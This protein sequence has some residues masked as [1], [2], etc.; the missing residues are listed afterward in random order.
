MV[1]G[2]CVLLNIR[3]LTKLHFLNVGKSSFSSAKVIT[4]RIRPHK[5]SIV[6]VPRLISAIYRY[7]SETTQMY[8]ETNLHSTFN[9]TNT[10]GNVNQQSNTELKQIKH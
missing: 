5:W 4:A 6:R 10:V 1:V 8:T 9:V 3:R 2:L 7:L